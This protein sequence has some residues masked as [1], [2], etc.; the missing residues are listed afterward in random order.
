MV[1]S[2][3]CEDLLDVSVVHQ[4]L[5]SCLDGLR[6]LL[7]I[8][9]DDDSLRCRFDDISD[10]LER[11][12]RLLN[13][14]ANN[15]GVSKGCIVLTAG[16]THCNVSLKVV[17]HDLHSLFTLSGAVI[18]QL[19]DVVELEGAILDTNS[20]SAHVRWIKVLGIALCNCEGGTSF[21][22]ADHVDFLLTVSSDREAGN[23][24]I[25]L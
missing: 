5:D 20:C 13:G 19:S 3:G 24:D 23:A 9:R 12:I 2:V 17:R 15:G 18:R 25:E 6:E 21:D 14:V 22:E 11:T 7:V 8:L 10:L 4:V 16:N 1:R